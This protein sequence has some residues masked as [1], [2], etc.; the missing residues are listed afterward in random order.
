MLLFV[1]SPFYSDLKFSYIRAHWNVECKNLTALTRYEISD[2]PREIGAYDTAL[3]STQLP[4]E[5]LV[6]YIMIR[7]LLYIRLCELPL[8]FFL[9]AWNQTSHQA[10]CDPMHKPRN[11]RN[12]LIYIF[13]RIF[14]P[15]E[16]QEVPAEPALFSLKYSSP[17]TLP[18][19]WYS[20]GEQTLQ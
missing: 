10:S 3:Q 12:T 20:P 17:H 7:S 2:Q 15:L 11:Y 5:L 1:V 4:H 9:S 14:N 18:S 8:L 6:E 19:A 16:I 13:L